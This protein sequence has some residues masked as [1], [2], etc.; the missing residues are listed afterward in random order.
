[1][2]TFVAASLCLLASPA[3]CV[4]GPA[5]EDP[6][7]ADHVVMVLKRGLNMAAFCTGV[8]IAPRVV[9]TAAHCAAALKDMRIHYRDEA[10]QPVLLEVDAVA[11][12]PDYRADAVTRRVVSI[13][14]ALLRARMPLDP[15][16]SAAALDEGGAAAVGAPLRIFG[17]GV[18]REGDGK[19]AG[20]L[21][22]AALRVRAPLSK[23]LL[24]AED[25]N[26]A[27]GGA[28]AG[29]SGGPIV[30]ED[31]RQVL[32]IAAWSA[33]RNAR[34]SCGGLTQGPLVAPQRAW[35]H[36]V[37]KGWGLAPDKE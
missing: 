4:V 29:D 13:D 7:F 6:S 28:C 33:G 26:D 34:R 23:I 37:L 19:S 30:A 12:H 10:G 22:S 11:V 20:V 17:Y 3:L 14:L 2:T 1:M 27:G 18:A 15:R 35:I 36:S 21:R 8:V 24:W 25:P 9:L 31:T 32:A 5:R 16:F